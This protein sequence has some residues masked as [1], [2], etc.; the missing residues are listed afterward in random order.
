VLGSGA[1]APTTTALI[2]GCDP[3]DGLPAVFPP[4]PVLATVT[5][6]SFEEPVEHL[7]TAVM[8]ATPA[9]T[10]WTFDG[11][12]ERAHSIGRSRIAPDAFC[13]SGRHGRGLACGQRQPA[14]NSAGTAGRRLPPHVFPRRPS[15]GA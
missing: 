15:P 14:T 6:A 11:T 3:R 13:V 12:A 1:K 5:N 7:E 9:G 4:A 8:T 10:G 2:P